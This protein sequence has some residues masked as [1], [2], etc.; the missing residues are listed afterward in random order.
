MRRSKSTDTTPGL[1]VAWQGF[2][3]NSYTIRR[4][5]ILAET[6]EAVVAYPDFFIPVAS[7]A[8]LRVAM[9]EAAARAEH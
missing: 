4:G 3:T 5:E 2:A 1:M 8:D 6:H 9:A 7:T